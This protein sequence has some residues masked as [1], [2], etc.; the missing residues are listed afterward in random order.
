MEHKYIVHDQIKR[1]VLE[2]EP[3]MALQLVAPLDGSFERIHQG[4]FFICQFV[5]VCRVNGRKIRISKFV[6]L[7]LYHYSALLIIYLVEEQT[8]VQ[9]KLRMS[10]DNLSFEF[11]L[12]YSNSLVHPR[13]KILVYRIEL[14]EV[15]H[16]RS[17]FFAVVISVSVLGKCCK[18]SQVEP[19]ADFEHIEVVVAD[20]HSQEVTDAGPVSGR[21]SHPY[22]IVIA[23][24]E[25]YI[26]V[27]HEVIEDI[28]RMSSPVKDIAYDMQFVDSEPRYRLGHFTDELVDQSTLCDRGKDLVVI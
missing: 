15:E 21:G 4:L 13:C 7:A 18:R 27:L 9:F 1:S 10:L 28:I 20:V 3:D 17:E 12:A 22:D 19:I 8:L 14:V 24:L 16:L 26:L 5:R 23:P 25:I 2:H 11:E 6:L